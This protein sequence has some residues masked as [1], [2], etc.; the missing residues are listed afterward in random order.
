MK[1]S[2]FYADAQLL[3]Q[4]EHTVDANQEPLVNAS[5]YVHDRLG[6]IRLLTDAGGS[7]VESYTYD[8]YGRPRVMQT[9]GPD[10][11][12][13]TEDVATYNTSNYDNPYMFTGQRWYGI[14]LYYYR[15]RDY[16]PI[17]GRFCQPDP[18]G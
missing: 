12:W 18:I 5:F 15:F 11:N 3:C 10:G 9:A 6:S 13:L 8:P 17:L 16:A 14:G 7:P 1:K 2:Y 4:Y